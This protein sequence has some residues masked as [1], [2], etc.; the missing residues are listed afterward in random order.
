MVTFARGK[1]DCICPIC[2]EAM[3]SAN[4]YRSTVKA[5]TKWR[6]YVGWCVDCN[7]GYYI[8]EQFNENENRW[9]II[10][11]QVYRIVLG[12]QVK[13]GTVE[14]EKPD[15]PLVCTGPGGSYVKKLHSETY[16]DELKL[17]EQVTKILNKTGKVILHFIKNHKELE[18]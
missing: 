5:G 6:S 16:Q 18:A 7:Q 9:I 14:V 3:H 1:D 13:L 8:D 4:I 12:R 17:M 15:E 11:Y 10:K 2:G